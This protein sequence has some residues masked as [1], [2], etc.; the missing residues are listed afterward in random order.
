MRGTY[1]RWIRR[2]AVAAIPMAVAVWIVATMALELAGAALPGRRGGVWGLV[3][4]VT[5]GS[6]AGSQSPCITMPDGIL[7]CDSP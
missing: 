2:I 1:L 7:I 5:A 3:P 4:G 6:E